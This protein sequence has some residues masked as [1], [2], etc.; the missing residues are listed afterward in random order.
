MGDGGDGQ[1]GGV[2]AELPRGQVREGAVVE[3]GEE[4][5]DDRVA[6]VLLLVVLFGSF[7]IWPLFREGIWPW[8]WPVRRAWA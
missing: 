1:P 8:R 4:Q 6:A 7:G 2:G 5:F 3:V